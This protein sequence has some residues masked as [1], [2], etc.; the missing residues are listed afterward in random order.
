MFDL[1]NAKVAALAAK[2]AAAAAS[3]AEAVRASDFVILSLNHA[4]IVR[5]VVFGDGGVAT[6][7]MPKNS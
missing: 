1:D 3:V 7:A 4:N 6:A 5:A 2:G